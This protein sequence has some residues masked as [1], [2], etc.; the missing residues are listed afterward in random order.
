[1]PR[2]NPGIA[3]RPVYISNQVPPGVTNRAAVFMLR[4][5]LRRLYGR[6]FRT[7]SRLTPCCR[8]AWA[9]SSYS[10]LVLVTP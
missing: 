8:A 2:K 5:R 3:K 7:S 6:V 10:A 4:E 9:R 1:M